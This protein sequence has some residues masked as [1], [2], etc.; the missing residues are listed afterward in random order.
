ML[1]LLNRREFI[2]MRTK[3]ALQEAKLKGVKLGGLRDHTNKRNKIAKLKAD[4]FAAKMW[5]VIEP[6][7]QCNY[8]Y[9]AIANRLNTQG[10]TTSN[11][12]SDIC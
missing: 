6:I 2:S 3:A 8:S 1:Q 5:L 10:F 12:S 11:N 7:T 9:Q 4:N